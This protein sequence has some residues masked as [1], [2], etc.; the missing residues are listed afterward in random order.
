M[1]PCTSPPDP[2]HV[3]LTVGAARLLRGLPD[4][5]VDALIERLTWWYVPGNEVMIEP[6]DAAEAIYV[7]LYGRAAVRSDLDRDGTITPDETVDELGP[8]DVVGLIAA[9]TGVAHTE[10]VVAARD[11]ELGRLG[12]DELWGLAGAF[13]GLARRLAADALELARHRLRPRLPTLTNVALVAGSAEVSLRAFGAELATALGVLEPVLFVTAS[14]FDAA[15]GAGASGDDIEAWD[16]TDR[17]IVAWVGEQERTH[18][19]ILYAADDDP[20]PWTDRVQRM[21]DRVLVVAH[22]GEDPDLFGAESEVDWAHAELVLLHPADAE[23]A[24][25]ARAWADRRPGLRRVHHLR[26]GRPDDLRRL[27][28]LLAGRPVCLVLGGGGARGAAQIGAVAALRDAGVPIDVVGGTSAGAGIA[29]MVALDWDDATMQARN[30]HAFLTLAPFS[31]YAVPFHSLLR[32]FRVEAAARYLF[33]DARVEDLWIEWFGVCADLV[34]GERVVLR[35][36][37]L[38]RAVLASTALPG[39]LPP[40]VHEGRLLVDGGIF[41]NNPVQIMAG[42]HPGG[43]LILVD[44]GRAEADMVDPQLPD[45][46]SNLA[47]WWARLWPFGQRPRV[48]TIPEILVRTMTVSR[49]AVQIR[50]LADL[51]VRP[52]VDRFGL[53]Q[54]VAQE[55]LVVI[56][57]NAT[58][59]ALAELAADEEACRTLGIDPEKIGALDRKRLRSEVQRDATSA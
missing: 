59:D 9:A 20:T 51:Y 49:D 4:A 47:A 43:F 24:S 13:P 30:R 44:V 27:A 36:G 31:Q 28:R 41:D 40:V 15:V 53:T 16:A 8:G 58:L 2:E 48:P 19:F 12:V 29:A 39:V 5:L 21:A 7:V 50:R 46:P 14:S 26:Q 52:A 6:G 17:R 10:Q 3:R 45:L 42:Q 18:R 54:F 25:G 23:L 22:A 56:G 32:K 35:S 11:C 33:G 37:P 57:Y 55:A 1:R 34:H 38:W